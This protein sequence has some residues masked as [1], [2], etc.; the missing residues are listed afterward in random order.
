VRPRCRRRRPQHR[1]R[2]PLRI[3]PTPPI[4]FHPPAGALARWWDACTARPPRVNGASRPFGPAA[5]AVDPP[6]PAG[7]GRANFATPLEHLRANLAILLGDDTA[8]V[9][10]IDDALGR[11][12]AFA[13]TTTSFGLED[14]AIAELQDLYVLPEAR[15]PVS[16]PSAN[17]TS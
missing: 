6:V 13:I 5:P 11:L 9:A 7:P 17:S 12:L 16:R 14:G 2:R 4:A 8:R 3:P 10:I 1:P 15:W